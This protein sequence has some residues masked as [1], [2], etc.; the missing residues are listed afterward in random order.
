M[1]DVVNLTKTN[2]PVSELVFA[3]MK[4]AI[5]GEKYQLSL[6]FVGDRRSKKLNQNYRQKNYVPNILSFEM[7]KNSGEIFINLNKVKKQQKKFDM[8]FR[9]LTKFLFIHGCLHLLGMDHGDKMEAK[10]NLYVGKF[11]KL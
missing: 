11:A 10:E 3:K 4:Q 8:E 1:F 2:S 9:E 5:L 6:A 7:E